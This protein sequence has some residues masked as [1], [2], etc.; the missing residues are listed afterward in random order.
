MLY[1]FLTVLLIFS[2]SIVFAIDQ[3][4]LGEKEKAADSMM[5]NKEPPGKKN[6]YALHKACKKGN[7]EKVIKLL[8]TEDINEEIGSS[9]VTPN[10]RSM[11]I[12]SSRYCY[13]SFI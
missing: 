3:N 6:Q 5:V 2:A 8:R 7:L 13:I 12:C 10:I 1:K 11:F 4:N 9:G